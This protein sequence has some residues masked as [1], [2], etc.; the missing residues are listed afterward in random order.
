MTDRIQQA[1]VFGTLDRQFVDG[2]IVD[3]KWNGGEWLAK[4]SED[5][6]HSSTVGY[7][8][9]DLHVHETSCTSVKSEKRK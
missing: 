2:V 5:V 4:L 7:F 8:G 9:N 3:H 6:P 1:G